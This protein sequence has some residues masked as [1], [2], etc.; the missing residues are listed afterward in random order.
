MSIRR[1]LLTGLSAAVISIIIL[2]GSL[3]VANTEMRATIAQEFVPTPTMTAVPTQIIVATP[4]PGQPTY[5][6]S[7]SPLPSSTSTAVLAACPPPAGWVPIT[8]QAGDSLESLAAVYNTTVKA[9]KQG[10]CLEGNTLYPG[11]WL[12]VPNTLP[13]TSIPCGPPSG[14]VYHIVRPGDNLFQISKI[15]G[16]SVSELQAANCMGSSTTIRVGQ[17]LYVPNVPPNFSPTPPATQT[18]LP[19]ATVTF[20][21]IPPSATAT[22]LPPS[23]TATVALPSLTPTVPTNTPTH[24]P[25]MISATPSWTATATYT[26]PPPTAT[27]TFTPEP[28][29]STPTEWPTSTTPPTATPI[30]PTNTPLPPTVT[31]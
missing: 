17:R 27:E 7:P 2:I 31:P 30:P 26:L 10:N 22:D 6:P 23:L 29:T 3:L 28:P 15:Y 1:E 20:T 24:T 8:V 13:P 14:W 25:V 11:T 18:P 5:T 9:L 19:T 16:V 12:Y 21:A 4:L